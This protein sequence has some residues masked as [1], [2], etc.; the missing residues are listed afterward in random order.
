MRSDSPEDGGTLLRIQPGVR[1]WTPA[2][3]LPQNLPAEAPP[4][5][6]GPM[7]SAVAAGVHGQPVDGLTLPRS[8]L[9]QRCAVPT[10]FTTPAN[11]LWCDSI[12]GSQ[13]A[14]ADESTRWENVID[15]RHLGLGLSTVRCGKSLE[16]SSCSYRTMTISD[17][18]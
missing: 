16:A 18:H 5:T 2:R 1:P 9:G 7:D 14:T 3:A 10:R 6:N 12:L 17:R 8:G 15:V 13:V 11:S 4:L